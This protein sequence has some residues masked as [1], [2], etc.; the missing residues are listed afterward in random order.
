MA[1]PEPSENEANLIVASLTSILKHH[2]DALVNEAVISLQRI[3]TSQ[4][5]ESDARVK[6]K[7]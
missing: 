6:T 2:D 3:I 7:K 5:Y 1:T 4:D